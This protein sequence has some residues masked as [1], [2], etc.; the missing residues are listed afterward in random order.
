MYRASIGF[1]RVCAQAKRVCRWFRFRLALPI[2][3]TGSR[4]RRLL[5][6]FG[7]RWDLPVLQCLALCIPRTPAFCTFRLLFLSSVRRFQEA[8]DWN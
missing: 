5:D 3:S 8:R 2:L 7:F 4:W 6:D 1:D